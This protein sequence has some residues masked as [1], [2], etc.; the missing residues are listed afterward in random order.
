MAGLVLEMVHRI[1]SGN[2]VW[3]GLYLD[4]EFGF[5]R[6]VPASPRAV[7]AIPGVRLSA[8]SLLM[9]RSKKPV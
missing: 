9:R 1:I 4:L 8:S 7:A 3:M 6:V 5:L 2:C